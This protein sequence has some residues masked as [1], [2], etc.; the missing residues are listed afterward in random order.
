VERRRLHEDSGRLGTALRSG[1]GLLY[2][3]RLSILERLVDHRSDLTRGL[4]CQPAL[5][6]SEF[7]LS[8]AQLALLA[9]KFSLLAS[10]IALFRTDL[11]LH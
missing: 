7:A 10:E 11:A 3:L 5:L 4:A 9:P 1:F 8:A 6:A 2:R